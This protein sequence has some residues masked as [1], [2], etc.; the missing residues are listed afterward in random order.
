MEETLSL[1]LI[2][3]E[4]SKGMVIEVFRSVIREY[5]IPI[6]D[7][8]EGIGENCQSIPIYLHLQRFSV[9]EFLIIL[10]W[11]NEMSRYLE[12]RHR[13]NPQQSKDSF[14]T[15]DLSDLLEKSMNLDLV[16]CCRLLETYSGHK[17]IL[18]SI[19]SKLT[20]YYV[21]RSICD[22][23]TR[24]VEFL[25]DTKGNRAW[26]KT[27]PVKLRNT[28][29]LPY[30]QDLR[31]LCNE[32]SGI[33]SEKVYHILEEYLNRRVASNGRLRYSSSI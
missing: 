13:M 9:N 19:Y 29:F 10:E 20:H 5:F 4:G 16:I 12:E 7:M 15:Q 26:L 31:S 21:T 23:M 2:E 22:V 14:M 33:E 24:S 30:V 27:M 17:F 1:E 25:L 8:W 6:Y 18:D 11:V 32:L 3:Y 28:I